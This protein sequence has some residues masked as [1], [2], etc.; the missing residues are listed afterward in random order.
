MNPFEDAIEKVAYLIG[1]RSQRQK[2][3]QVKDLTIYGQWEKT[4]SSN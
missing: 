2:M 1:F 3:I 4:I